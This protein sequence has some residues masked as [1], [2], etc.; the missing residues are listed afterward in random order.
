MEGFTIESAGNRRPGMMGDGR[1]DVGE[2][3]RRHETEKLCKTMDWN[4]GSMDSGSS[5]E[6][7]V[8]PPLLCPGSP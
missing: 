8:S 5:R 2:L 4:S 7:C 3:C 1:E 6:L